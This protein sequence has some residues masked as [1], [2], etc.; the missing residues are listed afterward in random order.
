MSRLLLLGLVTC[1]V[2]ASAQTSGGRIGSGGLTGGSRDTGR[3]GSGSGGSRSTGSSFG[4]SSSSGSSTTGS[5]SFGTARSTY[6]PTAARL[7]EEAFLSSHRLAGAPVLTDEDLGRL[8][9][10]KVQTLSP[11]RDDFKNSRNDFFVFFNLIFSAVLGFFA[12]MLSS[13]VFERV[14]LRMPAALLPRHATWRRVSVAFDWSARPQLQA[15]LKVLAEDP[16]GTDRERRTFVVQLATDLQTHSRAARYLSVS[17][18]H[19]SPFDVERRIADDAEALRKRYSVETVGRS[20]KTVRTFAR[21][22]EGKGLIVITLLV[23]YTRKLPLRHAWTHLDQALRQLRTGPPVQM[24]EVVWSPSEENDRLSSAELEVLYPELEPLDA[25]LGRASCQACAAVY[26]LELTKCPSCGSPD[27]QRVKG[28]GAPACPYCGVAMP[29]HET[30][31]QSCQ[32]F[33]VP[34]PTSRPSAT[35]S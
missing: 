5:S 22:I 25:R 13:E 6:D 27:A 18:G 10:V 8:T 33:V 14:T 3:S 9:R 12:V 2:V 20:R 16:I 11:F 1:S 28:P 7:A 29:G 24:L 15:A 26:A 17:E 34:Q 19:G 21:P 23:G 31:C 35:S 4:K 30:Q 32:A